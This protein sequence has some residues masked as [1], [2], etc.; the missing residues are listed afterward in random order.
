[1]STPSVT[2][3]RLNPTLEDTKLAQ[4]VKC[5]CGYIARAATAEEILSA[6]RAHLGSDHPQLF[7]KVSDEE[8]RSWIEVVA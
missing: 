2:K 3:G 4:Q 6:V 8:I 1:M 5:E 7:D